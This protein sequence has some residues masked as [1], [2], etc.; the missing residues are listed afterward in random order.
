MKYAVNEKGVEALKTM[1]DAIMTAISEVQMLTAYIQSVVN[2]NTI[3]LGTLKE[4]IDV[5]I[6]EINESILR[7][8]DPADRIA[9]QLEEISESYSEIINCPDILKMNTD[10]W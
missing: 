3:Q 7:A 5:S 10:N 1:A 4:S 9:N 6:D 2:E 8:K